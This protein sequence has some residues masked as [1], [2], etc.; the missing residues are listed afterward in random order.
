LVQ[1]IKHLP[2]S[3]RVRIQNPWKPGVRAHVYNRVTPVWRWTA[4]TWESPE[5]PRLAWCMLWWAKKNRA[6]STNTQGC[7]LNYTHTH[8]HTHTHTIGHT[9]VHS[10]TGMHPCAYTSKCILLDIHATCIH[11]KQ[12]CDIS[13]N[14][15]LTVLSLSTEGSISSDYFKL[16]IWSPLPTCADMLV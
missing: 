16:L 12:Y 14:C 4:E 1:W 8:T 2:C 15:T 13:I 7:P 10:L 9:Y 6:I 11:I 5:A 3:T